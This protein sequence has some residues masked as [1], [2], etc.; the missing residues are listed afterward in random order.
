MSYAAELFA[1]AV[2]LYL[3]DASALLYLN[4]AIL[5][6]GGDGRWTATSGWRGF[7]F[8]GRSLCMLNPFTPQ[9]PAFRLAW[10]FEAP[11]DE[12]ADG[13][14]ANGTAPL[15]TLTPTVTIAAYAL[16][17][18][19][20]LGLFTPLRAY[21]VIPALIA[22]YASIGIA[23]WRLWRSGTLAVG[24]RHRF[25]AFAFEC[26]ACPPFAVNMIRR[27]TLAQ[28]VPESLPLAAARLLETA[29]WETLRVELIERLEQEIDALAAGSELRGRLE[30]QKIRLRSLGG[31]PTAAQLPM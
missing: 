21:A 4:E 19:L 9:W 14:W 2:T 5:I 25:W 10:N 22:L 13:A 29:D 24:G 12:S 3:Y 15:R 11:L 23:L 27:I 28:R 6:R 18:L 17:V 16:F 20:P 31:A 30:A 8:A 7:V 26:A 1:L